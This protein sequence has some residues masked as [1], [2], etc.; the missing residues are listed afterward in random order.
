MVRW[1]AF[2]DESAEA[3]VSRFKRGAAEIQPGDAV[4]SALELGRPSLVLLPARNSGRVLM[5]RF[6]TTI[7]EESV[8]AET[9][10][11]SAVAV[12]EIAP[13]VEEFTPA[14]ETTVLEDDLQPIA[15]E[16]SGFLGLTDQPLYTA[17]EPAAKRKWW[18]KLTS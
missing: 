6:Q 9:F 4:G 11:Q 18:Q 17:P 12:E 1:V 7:L 14:A 15:Y 3:V 16:T 5:A 13:P 8:P 10:E 2:D